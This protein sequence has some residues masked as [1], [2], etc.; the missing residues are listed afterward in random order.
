MNMIEVETGYGQI[1]L[2]GEE[3]HSGPDHYIK[4]N[5]P[6]SA[7]KMI[8]FFDSRGISG[9]WETSLLNQLLDY[10]DAEP[11]LAISR[12]LELTTWATLYNFMQIN[13]LKP[14]RLITNIG[15]VDFTPKKRLLCESMIS[16]INFV[17]DTQEAEI[18][19]LDEWVLSNGER[20]TL[21]TVEYSEAYIHRL[22]RYFTTIPLIA[23]KTPLVD[24]AIDITRFRPPTF[25]TQLQKTNSFIDRLDCESIDLGCFDHSLTYDAVH[26]TE[27]GNRLVFEKIRKY[28]SA[29]DTKNSM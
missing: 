17:S 18:Q 25:F 22:K 6:L 10:Y 1:K 11:Y 26:W 27:K 21:S 29:N 13:D 12:P 23:I 8:F 15:I 5:C 7:A 14:E 28:L 3:L 2:Y 24:A 20:Q 16:Q 4:A 9:N 19:E